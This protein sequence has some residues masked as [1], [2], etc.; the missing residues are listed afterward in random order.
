[1][2]IVQTSSSN[3][4]SKD[5]ER[6]GELIGEV[7]IVHCNSKLSLYEVLYLHDNKD[8]CKRRL[9]ITVC[10][11]CEAFL[12]KLIQTRIRDN[13]YYETLYKRDAARKAYD[14]YVLETMYKSS[15]VPRHRNSTFGLC[16]G[17]YT[18]KKDKD[19]N[20]IEVVEKAK[21]FYNHTRVLKK[22]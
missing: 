17:V 7:M 22:F 13:H 4:L 10:P 20:V 3:F 8:F 2:D 14:K 16:Y 1:M 5:C 9:E 18:E 15:D 12:A 6:I 19:G 21:D 11:H